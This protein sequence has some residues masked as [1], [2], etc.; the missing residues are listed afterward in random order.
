MNKLELFPMVL[1]LAL[2]FFTGHLTARTVLPQEK[3]NRA[4]AFTLELLKGGEVKSS[5]L[6]GKITVLKFMAS[7]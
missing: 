7:Y 6:N 1:A 3:D 5:E 2:S 4:P